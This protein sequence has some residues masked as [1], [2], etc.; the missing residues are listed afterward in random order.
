MKRFYEV[1]LMLSLMEREGFSLP[2]YSLEE[3]KEIMDNP[4]RPPYIFKG[5]VSEQLYSFAKE[6]IEEFWAAHDLSQFMKTLLYQSP[7]KFHIFFFIY[8][9][10]VANYR[11]SINWLDRGRYEKKYDIYI[12]DVYALLKP[13]FV[14]YYGAEVGYSHL[15]NNSHALLKLP[16]LLADEIISRGYLKGIKIPVRFSDFDTILERILEDNDKTLALSFTIHST[17][18][19]NIVGYGIIP[20]EKK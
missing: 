20:S 12:K 18:Y 15:I 2:P 3:L 10:E 6:I 7:S 14:D 5:R 1:N 8:L 16:A 4:V 13:H 19:A 11:P 9:K 17:Y